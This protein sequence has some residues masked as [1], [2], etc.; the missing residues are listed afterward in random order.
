MQSIIVLFF[1]LVAACIAAPLAPLSPTTNANNNS[2]T[3]ASDSQTEVD[4]NS[5]Q[6]NFTTHS[7]EE[8]LSEEEGEFSERLTAPDI[9]VPL[10]YILSMSTGQFVAITKSGRVQANTQIGK[11]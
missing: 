4:N 5:G 3:E 2:A 6:Q 11:H 1:L 8:D 7:E 9:P 10:Q